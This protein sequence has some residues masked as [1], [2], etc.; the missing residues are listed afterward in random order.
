MDFTPPSLKKLVFAISANTYKYLAKFEKEDDQR[1]FD[2]YSAVFSI[3]Q[4]PPED[5]IYTIFKLDTIDKFDQ[6]IKEY[7]T[8]EDD[9]IRITTDD[10]GFHSIEYSERE[11]QFLSDRYG[12]VAPELQV[13]YDS[14]APQNNIFQNSEPNNTIS[15]DSLSSMAGNAT[16]EN[17]TV[18]ATAGS[19]TGLII[20][21]A[22]Q[23][24]DVGGISGAGRNRN[25]SN[26]G[27]TGQV[28]EEASDTGISTGTV[29][30]SGY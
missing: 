14:D 3:F 20:E 15:Y 30:T 24:S 26:T 1:F 12:F 19:T 25:I 16:Q 11:S 28:A 29:T 7:Y 8:I 27:A 10:F 2:T 18:S 22:E 23:I 17:F 21:E 13:T 4:T 6:Q 5:I 9:T